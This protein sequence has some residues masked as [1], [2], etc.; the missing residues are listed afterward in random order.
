VKSTSEGDRTAWYDRP[1][2]GARCKLDD[3]LPMIV[4]LGEVADGGLVPLS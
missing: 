3:D 1:A 4:G 2:H